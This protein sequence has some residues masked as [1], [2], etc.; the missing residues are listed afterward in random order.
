MQMACSESGEKG[1]R[2][3]CQTR[4]P[5]NGHPEVGSTR[6]SGMVGG[7]AWSGLSFA[8]NRSRQPPKQVIGIA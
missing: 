7:L 2:G 4:S 6:L 1:G 3:I 5:A 8:T